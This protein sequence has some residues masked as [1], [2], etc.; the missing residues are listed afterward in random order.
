MVIVCQLE[1]CPRYRDRTRPMVVRGETESVWHF[2]C[3]SCLNWRVIHKS[4]IGG[5]L[6]AGRSERVSQSLWAV[7]WSPTERR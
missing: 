5:T 2:Y 4:R 3:P 1:E 7:S 6:G